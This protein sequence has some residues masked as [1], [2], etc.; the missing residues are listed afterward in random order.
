MERLPVSRLSGRA[1]FDV[2][3]GWE[4]HQAAALFSLGL[5]SGGLSYVGLGYHHRLARQ[6]AS[7]RYGPFRIC[8]IPS[9]FVTCSKLQADFSKMMA[10]SF[11][12]KRGNDLIETEAAIDDRFNGGS[13]DCSNELRLMLAAAYYQAYPAGLVWPSNMRS[14]S[15]QPGQLALLSGRCALQSPRRL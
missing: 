2:D 13:V 10:A 9:R 3:G 15:H 8:A 5:G 4:M 6:R 14:G 12:S 1:V 11:K 7:R